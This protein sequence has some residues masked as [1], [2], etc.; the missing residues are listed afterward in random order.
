MSIQVG[1]FVDNALSSDNA[2]SWLDLALSPYNDGNNFDS[3]SRK[4]VVLANLDSYIVQSRRLKC[5]SNQS[6][7][8]R[9]ASE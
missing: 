8:Q 7:S 3:V 4:W 6:E 5:G 2:N 1:N 9:K